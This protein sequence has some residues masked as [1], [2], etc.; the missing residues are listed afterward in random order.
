MSEIH[1]R[2]DHIATLRRERLSLQKQVDRMKQ[3]EDGLAAK[4]ASDM[5]DLGMASCTGIFGKL[6]LK[7]VEV[8]EVVS[9]PELYQYILETSSF[10]LLQRRLS[11]AGVRERWQEGLDVPGV[12]RTLEDSYTL[13]F[14]S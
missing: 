14:A 11:L 3:E 7:V 13:G 12:A 10:D 4:L 9:Y 2:L 5:R 6:T 1:E 8:P